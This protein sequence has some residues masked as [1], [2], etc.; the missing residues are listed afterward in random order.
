MYA[1]PIHKCIP[2]ILRYTYYIRA[3]LS[4]IWVIDIF[5][6]R[7]VPTYSYAVFVIIVLSAVDLILGH[8]SS[9]LCSV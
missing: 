3:E 5:I 2:Y 6:L 1:L 4:H 8:L 7:K 9:S